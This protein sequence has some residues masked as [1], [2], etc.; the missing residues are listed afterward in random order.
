MFLHKTGWRIKQLISHRRHSSLDGD[1]TT[2]CYQI[3]SANSVNSTRGSW[4]Y[5][6]PP[7]FDGGNIK[8]EVG[9]TSAPPSTTTAYSSTSSLC[10]CKSST[11]HSLSDLQPTA[12]SAQVL[13]LPLLPKPATL[14]DA[15][16]WQ[17]I[18]S[19]DITQTA[20]PSS[21]ELDS[22]PLQIPAG[23]REATFNL[24]EALEIDPEEDHD[25][26][27]TQSILERKGSSMESSSD[28]RGQL[29]EEG[30]NPSKVVK[31][32][33]DMTRS[34]TYLNQTIP[35]AGSQADCIRISTTGEGKTP[36]KLPNTRSRPRL[37]AKNQPFYHRTTRKLGR[38]GSKKVH[39]RRV[40]P[41]RWK[42]NDVTANIVEV[43][44][45]KIFKTEVDEMLTPK[46]V[47]QIKA[48]KE[49]IALTTSEISKPPR[50]EDLKEFPGE[51]VS[52]AVD[53][54]SQISIPPY[55]SPVLPPPS[56][57]AKSPSQSLTTGFR[58][59]GM[60]F[61]SLEFPS[62]P[63]KLIHSE[64]R[65]QTP[66]PLVLKTPSDTL[67]SQ[68]YIIGD[69]SGDVSPEFRT[70]WSTPFSLTSPLFRHGPIRIQKEISKSKDDSLDWTAFQIAILGTMNEFDY[71]ESRIE[72]EEMDELTEWLA[73]FGFDSLGALICESAR[74]PRI[75]VYVKDDSDRKASWS[76]PLC[77]E[78]RW[79]DIDWKKSRIWGVQ[80]EDGISGESLPQNPVVDPL[81][82]RAETVIPMSHN[83][84]HDLG[85]FLNW[86]AQNIRNLHE[87][88]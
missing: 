52:V 85:D 66:L 34:S 77:G 31:E 23:E 70:L 17:L 57:P 9:S 82:E 22:N 60:V 63:R 19:K 84:G 61:G 35:F 51:R 48:A 30:V 88:M 50:G 78:S 41:E 21:R 56:I 46:R 24:I 72:E 47:Q 1:D 87:P 6:I 13:Y 32:T 29:I 33:T 76:G 55:P 44:S 2:N 42:L 39:V 73:A 15:K 38:T 69:I 64:T 18:L 74:P 37:A 11:D 67:H 8:K 86:E 25:K 75:E 4:N 83:L 54:A 12:S 5:Q 10:S 28:G 59:S 14:G 79:S 36:G 71:E 3:R 49:R 62:P 53:L 27:P 26:T 58:E 65:G 20:T 68:T 43:F 80:L 45:G 81:P 16:T 7:T 40:A